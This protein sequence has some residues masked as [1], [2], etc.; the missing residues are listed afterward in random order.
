[1]KKKQVRGDLLL[2]F[3]GS[4]RLWLQD[5]ETELLLRGD[6]F[7]ATPMSGQGFLRN[8]ALGFFLRKILTTWLGFRF[9]KL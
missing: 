6:E 5:D 8:L 7:H 2:K 4:Y 9:N 3:S 1:M